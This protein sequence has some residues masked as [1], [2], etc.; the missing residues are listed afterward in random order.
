MLQLSLAKCKKILQLF[1]VRRTY[2][3][4]FFFT[5]QPT[6]TPHDDYCDQ[7]HLLRGPHIEANSMPAK[8]IE[9]KKYLSF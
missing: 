6:P 5:N 9:E 3:D 7:K 2:P 4:I 8:K 1:T